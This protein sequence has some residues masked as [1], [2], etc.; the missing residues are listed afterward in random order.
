ML[1]YHLPPPPH[2]LSCIGRLHRQKKHSERE[3]RM[4]DITAVIAEGSLWLKPIRR[5]KKVWASINTTVYYCTSSLAMF[6]EA[7]VLCVGV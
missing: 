4:A 3:K 5:H 2:S 7:L 1:S 6:C